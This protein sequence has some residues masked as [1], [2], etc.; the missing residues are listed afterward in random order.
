M[1][2][3]LI[4]CA[5]EDREIRRVLVN[6]LTTLEQQKLIRIWHEGKIRNGESRQ[7]E[8]LDHLNRANIILLL[9]NSNFTADKLCRHIT[10]L[11]LKRSHD[12]DKV[13]VIPIL[14]SHVDLQGTQ[15]AR[16]KRLPSDDKPVTDWPDND[17]AWVDVVEGIRKV[18]FEFS[19]PSSS[20]SYTPQSHKTNRGPT[21]IIIGVVLFLLLVFGL[22]ILFNAINTKNTHAVTP[23]SSTPTAGPIQQASS[24]IQQYYADIN[25]KDFQQAYMLWVKCPQTL[26]QFEQD[27]CP[28]TVS[29]FEQGYASTMHDDITLGE[30]VIQTDGS[31]QVPVTVQA[32]EDA[33]G[34]KSNTRELHGNYTV[35][36]QSNG[37]WKFIGGQMG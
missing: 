28:Q 19:S 24:V 14:L 35:K 25:N 15:I 33:G 34:G 29:Q 1:V 36:Q 21:P 23:P 30:A 18:M 32:T 5:H 27:Y 37:I 7:T 11:A 2:N 16:L 26:S 3:V 22:S 8:I 20:A 9:I 10:G 12:S 6:H 31:V 17:K 4:W 13:R